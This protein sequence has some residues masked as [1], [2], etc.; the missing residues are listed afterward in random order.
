MNMK[1]KKEMENV[2]KIEKNVLI[3]QYLNV[4]FSDF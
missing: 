4:Y 3:V 1:K 2:E